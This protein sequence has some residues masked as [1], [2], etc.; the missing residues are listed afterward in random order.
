MCD[1]LLKE[2]S[3]VSENSLPLTISDVASNVIRD[4]P[5]ELNEHRNKSVKYDVLEAYAIIS[6]QDQ[7]GTYEFT[8]E[9]PFLDRVFS[10]IS[11]N[12]MEEKLNEL[13]LEKDTFYS[14]YTCE[15]YSIVIG[16][17]AKIFFVINTH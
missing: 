7:I 8:E 16:S 1:S 15:P 4:Y 2:A 10:K 6:K 14:I 11:R 9:F 13:A 5:S 3:N 12:R 17:I